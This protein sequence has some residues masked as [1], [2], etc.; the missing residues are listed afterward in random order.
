LLTLSISKVGELSFRNEVKETS[1]T[2][3]NQKEEVS[4]IENLFRVWRQ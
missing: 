1:E 3:L 4:Y 2:P